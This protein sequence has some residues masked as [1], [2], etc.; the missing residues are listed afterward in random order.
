MAAAGTCRAA[1]WL[2]HPKNYRTVY[3]RL[4]RGVELF[5]DYANEPSTISEPPY[6]TTNRYNSSQQSISA[7]LNSCTLLYLLYI[8]GRRVRQRNG[9]CTSSRR[10]CQK[11]LRMRLN[12]FMLHNL[13]HFLLLPRRLW[14][15]W[16]SKHKLRGRA[17][18]F[19]TKV[20]KSQ[21]RGGRWFS[22]HSRR[23]AKEPPPT[24]TICFNNF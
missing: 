20:S 9:I 3:M 13:H 12:G 17:G 1:L 19:R 16:C 5:N 23:G 4:R 2:S 8:R 24:K 6:K 10:R 18:D 15:A 14:W 7:A 22:M 21:E 11:N